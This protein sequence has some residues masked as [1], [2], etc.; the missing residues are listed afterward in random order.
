MALGVFLSVGGLCWPAFRRGRGRRPLRP[1]SR[2]VAVI[3]LRTRKNAPF[4]ERLSRLCTCNPSDPES[5]LL[6]GPCSLRGLLH[7]ARRAGLSSDGLLFGPEASLRTRF[8][9]VCAD[10]ELPAAWHAFRRGMA[11]DMLRG[12]SPI[13]EILVAGSWRSGAFLRYLR[14]AELDTRASV[15]VSSSADPGVLEAVFDH[16]GSD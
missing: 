15:D 2:L 7:D 8:R 3:L 9:R 1:A 4:G 6:C 11:A 10:L 12:G 13:G 16:S 14:R 5:L